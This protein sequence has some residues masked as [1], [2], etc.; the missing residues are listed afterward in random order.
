[1][2]NLNEII[3]VLKNLSQDEKSLYLHNMIELCD[4]DQARN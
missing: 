1:M 3:V 2:E 4:K